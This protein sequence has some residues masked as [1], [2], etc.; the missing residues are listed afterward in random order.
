MGYLVAA[1]WDVFFISLCAAALI[2]FGR[3]HQ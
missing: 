1:F 3:R 2:W